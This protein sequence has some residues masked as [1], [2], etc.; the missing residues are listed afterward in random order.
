ML[1]R[2]A[3]SRRHVL[4]GYNVYFI[5]QMTVVITS[6]IVVAYMLYTVDARTVNEFGSKHLIYSIPLVYYG[7]FR[8]LYLIHK[9]HKEGDP[10]R[11][12]FS[13]RAMQINLL[14]WIIVCVFVIY[15]KV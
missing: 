3:A 1:K 8:Y 13:D 10:T 6:S 14:L 15:F 2:G 7:I 5:D 11:I 4:G 12:L 9:L